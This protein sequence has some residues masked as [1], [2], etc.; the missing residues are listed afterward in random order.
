MIKYAIDSFVEGSAELARKV[1]ESDDNMDN[2]YAENRKI[3]IEIMKEGR[4]NIEPAVTLLGISRQM[5]RLGDLATNIAE[6]VFFIVEAQLIKHKY[7]KYLFSEED[8]VDET[9]ED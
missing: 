8:E 4:E 1:I 2:M 9:T 7:E 3:L 5:E 6:D